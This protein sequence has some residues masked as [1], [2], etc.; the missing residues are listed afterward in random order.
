MKKIILLTWSCLVS[1]TFSNLLAQQ[2][3]ISS[4]GNATGTGGTVSYT[5]GQTDYNVA[6]GTN[7]NIIQGMQQPFEISEITGIG[8]KGIE[9]FSTIYPNPSAGNLTLKIE[10]PESYEQLSL[11]IYDVTGKVLIQERIFNTETTVHLSNFANAK[12]FLKV[13]N[14]G[15][16]LKT[17]QIIKIN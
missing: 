11:R 2:G 15:Q 6:S 13:I 7:G 14:K 9:L 1:W 16:E 3:V 12:Y 5:I 10:N 8:M 4:G 17:Y